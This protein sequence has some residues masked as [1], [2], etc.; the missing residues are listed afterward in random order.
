LDSIKGWKFLEEL[1]EYQLVKNAS[2]SCN[3]FVVMRCELWLYLKSYNA[4]TTSRFKQ[5]YCP[6]KYTV[7]KNII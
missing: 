7:N 5:N 2:A 4:Y 6:Y 3:Q 1:S